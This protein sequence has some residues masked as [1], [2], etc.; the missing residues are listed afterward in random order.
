MDEKHIQRV[1]E[2]E[3]KAEEIHNAATREAQQLP[4][5]A[6]QEAAALIE[7]AQADAQ[8]KAREILSEVKADEESAR[9]LTEVE[10]KNKQS[11]ALALN[12]FDQA[13]NFVIERLNGRG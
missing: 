10:E 4:V 5:T 13:V 2:I 9:I 8:Q 7:K 1:L 3:K 6:E 12:N 11:E